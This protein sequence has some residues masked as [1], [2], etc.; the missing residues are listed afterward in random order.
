MVKSVDFAVRDV[1]GGVSRGVV[2]GEG[3]SDFIQVSTGDDYLGRSHPKRAKGA[4]SPPPTLLRSAKARRWGWQA[5][6]AAGCALYWFFSAD[7]PQ[8]AGAQ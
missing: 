8:L 6:L 1:A 3:A 5:H 4:P 7:L 2:S